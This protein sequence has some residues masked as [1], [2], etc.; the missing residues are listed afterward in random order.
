MNTATMNAR[1]GRE[2]DYELRFCSLFDPGR[3][4][5]FPCDAAG[6]VDLDRLSHR[7]RSNYFYARTM[8]G[9]EL[10]MPAVQA[11]NLH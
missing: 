9:R 3:G 7:G 2:A 5:S 11:C 1:A 6:Q 8:I 4:Y 10:S